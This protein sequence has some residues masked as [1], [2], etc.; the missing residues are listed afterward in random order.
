MDQKSIRKKNNNNNY[1]NFSKNIYFL[2]SDELSKIIFPK[3]YVNNEKYV[4]KLTMKTKF[5]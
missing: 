3:K 4:N 1:P 5:I 2:F